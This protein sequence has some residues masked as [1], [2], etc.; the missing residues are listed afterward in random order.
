VFYHLVRN[1]GERLADSNWEHTVN[2]A[3]QSNRPR[4]WDQ[5][6]S[7]RDHELLDANWRK[8]APFGLG[9]QPA[10]LVI[11]NYRGSLGDRSLP[12]LEAI[13]SW[14]T[15]CGSDGW[16]AVARTKPILDYARSVGV[17][18]FYSTNDSHGPEWAISQGKQR[19]G[20]SEV[21]WERRY[22]IVGEIA[23]EPGDTVIVKTSPSVFFGTPLMTYLTMR[24][25]DTLLICGNST[26]GCVRATTVDAS[27]YRLNVGVIEECCFD[28]TEATHAINLFD[29][30]QKYADVISDSE[31]TAY[32]RSVGGS[33]NL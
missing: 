30:E 28:R 24:H 2:V 6:L 5:F 27:S 7:E 19:G 10:V 20:L 32:L 12:L 18:V 29:I 14:P 13:K 16:E 9:Q 17:P 1:R 8:Q 15:S 4:I 11:D 3:D 21:D 22:E 26:S 33:S 23:P 31:A 25:I